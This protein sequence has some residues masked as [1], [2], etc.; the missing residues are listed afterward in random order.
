MPE[1]GDMLAWLHCLF[2]G[3]HA[4]ERQIIG[5]FRCAE[6]GRAGAD[7]GEMGFE[8]FGYAP[9]LRRAIA[10]RETRS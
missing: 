3:Y 7:L 2:R 6:C 5:G 9:V 10:R 1:G 4:P 8:N